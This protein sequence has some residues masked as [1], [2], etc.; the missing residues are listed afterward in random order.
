MSNEAHWEKVYSEKSAVDVS[1]YQPHLRQSLQLITA[2]QLPASARIVDVGGGASTLVDDLLAL[3]FTDL[4]VIDLAATAFRQSQE[5][6]RERA[7]H[8]TWLQ[9]DATT[10]L[11]DADSVDLWHDRAVFHFLTD[12]PR[13]A[14][15]LE[16]VSRCVRPGQFVILGTFA[17]NGP[18]R[19]SG[20]P[21][22]RYSPDELASALGPTFEKLAEASEEHT[23]PRGAV[24]PFSYVLCRRRAAG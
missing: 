21:V 14:A 24:Q 7:R 6:L 13:R 1:W 23:S 19:C 5:R 15:Y 18:E 20:L 17:P 16:Q 22:A 8:V 3:G 10:E 2:C 11:L 9:G 4:T 12:E